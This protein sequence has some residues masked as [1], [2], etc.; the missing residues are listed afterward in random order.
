M[1][2]LNVGIRCGAFAGDVPIAALGIV[3]HGT[4]ARY[5]SVGADE[6]HRRRGL[7]S[8]HR[9]ARPEVHDPDD[10]QVRSAAMYVGSNHGAL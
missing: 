2:D 1:H 9:G 5:Q 6:E 8:R 10:D 3:R 4:T 7:A